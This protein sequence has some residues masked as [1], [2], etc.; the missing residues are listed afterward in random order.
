VNEEV[1]RTEIAG[2]HDGRRSRSTEFIGRFE[3]ACRDNFTND[4]DAQIQV[5]YY[6][7]KEAPPGFEPGMKILQTFVPST[8]T[9]CPH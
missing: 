4:R 8:Q 3:S 6:R 9:P 1:E 7:V 5:C 2:G